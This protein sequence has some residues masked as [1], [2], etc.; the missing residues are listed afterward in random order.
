MENMRFGMRFGAETQS[1]RRR[2][3]TG[4]VCTP[5]IYASSLNL[6]QESPSQSPEVDSR[7]QGQG[8]CTHHLD[9]MKTSLLELQASAGLENSP[10]CDCRPEG[11]NPFAGSG[12]NAVASFACIAVV[13]GVDVAAGG[14]ADGAADGVGGVVGVVAAVDGNDG[15]GGVGDVTYLSERCSGVESQAWVR[16]R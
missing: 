1:E 8:I 7:S 3:V 16:A 9:D 10:D 6:P 5:A 15:V 13:V 12:R 14:V 11:H 2:V 4:V